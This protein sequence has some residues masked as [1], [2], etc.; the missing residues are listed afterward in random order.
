MKDVHE[1]TL[2]EHYDIYDGVKSDLKTI[3]VDNYYK[4][5]L[6][7]KDN[8]NI[9]INFGMEIGLQPDIYDQVKEVV[10]TYDFDFIIGSS[11]ITNKKDMSKDPSFF[12]NL[13]SIYGLELL[14]IIESDIYE[15]SDYVSFDK[16]DLIYLNNNNDEMSKIRVKALIKHNI[17]TMCYETGDTLIY[18][19]EFDVYGHI[20]YVVRYGGYSEKE[21]NYEEFKDI[22]DKILIALIS[23]GKGIEIN[24]SGLRYNLPD[25]H[26]NKT[27]IKRYKDLGGSIITIGSDAHN[28]K[29][30]A[31]NFDRAY[32]I[33][34]ECGFEEYTIFHSRKPEFIKLPERKIKIY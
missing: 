25:M 10:N 29:D 20:D 24:T 18:K 8:P 17:Y 4:E 3:D 5:Y 32:N 30:L 27:I 6:K 33:L 31:D 21:I 13:S 9:K 26:P 7:Y 1:I 34:R 28:S 12:D 15:L 23:S 22:L 16:L 11:H 19:D 2:T 14:D